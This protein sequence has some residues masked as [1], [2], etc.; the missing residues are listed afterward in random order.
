MPATMA[1]T[2]MNVGVHAK[3][4]AMMDRNAV[5]MAGF[6]HPNDD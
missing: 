2:G 5:E 4:P 1:P 6:M 3:L